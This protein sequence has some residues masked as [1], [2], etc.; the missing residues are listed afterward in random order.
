MLAMTQKLCQ[1]DFS[2]NGQGLYV[3][4]LNELGKADDQK[5]SK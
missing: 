3:L 5:I 4:V 2:G 1:K